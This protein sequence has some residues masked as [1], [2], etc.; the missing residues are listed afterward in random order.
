MS[1]LGGIG[2]GRGPVPP[3]PNAQNRELQNPVTSTSL[4]KSA[5]WGRNQANLNEVVPIQV[6]LTKPPVNPN[7]AIEIYFNAPGSK[8]ELVEGPTT[9][10]VNGMTGIGNW[11]TKNSK[12]KD[13]SKGV[14]TFRVTI[15]RQSVVSDGLTLM[16]DA[17]AR[18]LRRI[19]TDGFD[20]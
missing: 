20:R 16:S 4:I 11:H 9:L 1:Y 5:K 6:L 2:R 18:M 13:L 12:G 14:F 7:A 10:R 19:N 8:P 3:A 17:M 15:D